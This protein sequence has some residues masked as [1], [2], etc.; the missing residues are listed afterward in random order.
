MLQVFAVIF[1]VKK[2]IFLAKERGIKPTSWAVWTGILYGVVAFSTSIA[3]MVL[4][5]LGEIDAKWD[6]LPH[7]LLVAVIAIF[8]GLLTALIPI[9]ILKS[10]PKMNDL[11]S[12]VFDERVLDEDI[13][14]KDI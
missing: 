12:G 4:V 14:D 1:L 5:E 7:S 8:A 9:S 13:L 3:A 10:K 6:E 11:P 2:I